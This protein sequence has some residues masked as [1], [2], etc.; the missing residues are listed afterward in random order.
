MGQDHLWNGT[1]SLLL[2]DD[3]AQQEV[4]ATVRDVEV[5][6]VELFLE[7][8]VAVGTIEA[9]SEREVLRS[10][11]L[12]YNTDYPVGHLEQ[13]RS[14]N[15]AEGILLCRYLIMLALLLVVALHIDFNV[16]DG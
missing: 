4:V 6:Q 14:W 15:V 2:V 10:K 5:A 9:G 16:L 8:D 13:L 12:L 1:E 7:F 11:S 3:P